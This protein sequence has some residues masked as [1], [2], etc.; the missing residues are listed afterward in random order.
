MNAAG[1]VAWRF[2]RG[3]V[4]ARLGTALMATLLENIHLPVGD[5]SEQE[6]EALWRRE[7]EYAGYG[8]VKRTLSGT[9]GWSEGRRQFAFRWLRDKENEIAQRE[10]QMQLDAGRIE[11]DISQLRRDLDLL[12]EDTAR[13]RADRALTKREARRLLWGSFGAVAIAALSFFVSVGHLFNSPR[14]TPDLLQNTP[15]SYSDVASTDASR[16]EP[17]DAAQ[18]FKRGGRR[19][20]IARFGTLGP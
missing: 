12:Q 16:V 13:L 15:A 7:F 19:S 1:G 17:R 14:W 9:N 20:R 5:D 8:A 3:P 6:Q 2:W 11:N 4:A 10:K 18:P